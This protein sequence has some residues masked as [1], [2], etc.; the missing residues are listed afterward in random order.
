MK[1]GIE[2]R[3]PSLSIRGKLLIA[4]VGLSLGPLVLLAAY[5][6]VAA[7]EALTLA[8]TKHLR[9]QLLS[10]AG[11]I[12]SYLQRLA[13]DA[14]LIARWSEQA[15]LL[16]QKPA[17]G[18]RQFD[19]EEFFVQFAAVRPDIY[20]IRLLDLGGSELLRVNHSGDRLE[21]VP[22]GGLQNKSGRYYFRQ[23]VA[24]PSDKTYFSPIDLNVE[25][26]RVETPQRLV[27]RVA[28]QVSGREGR[29][30][31][32][33]VLNVF[34]SEIL[35]RLELLQPEASGN[36]LLIGRQG[37]F[38]HNVCANGRCSYALG[39]LDEYL[40]GFAPG[41]VASI[42]AGET[43]VMREGDIRMEPHFISYAPVQIGDSSGDMQLRLAIV[44]PCDVV[45]A[46]VDRM[47]RLFALFGGVVG[48]IAL[49]LAGLGARALTIPIQRILRFLRGVAQGDFEQDLNVHTRDEIEQLAHGVRETARALQ[50]AQTRLVGWNEELQA[51]VQRQVEEIERLLDTK[52]TMEQQVR[53]ADRLASLGLL[54]ASL[55]HEIGNPLASIKTVI[56]VH[57]KDPS[58]A[59][60]TRRALEIVLSQLDRLEQIL[61]RVRG[62]AR[63]M[64][65]RSGTAT[66]EEVYHRV[67]LLTERE[68]RKKEIELSLEGDGVGQSLVTEGQQLDQVLLNLVVNA[69]QAMDGPGKITVSAS[70][71]DGHVEATV[72]DTGPGIPDHLRARVF[73][74]FMTTK[75]GGTGL[76]LPIVRQIVDEMKGEVWIDATAEGGARIHIRL[77]L[78]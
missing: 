61:E 15:A 39:Q 36:V 30:S 24:L 1:L 73:E 74:P 57:L 6:T 33:I 9:A 31:G 53:Q 56:Q 64:R 65:G 62:F 25:H 28:H 50:E 34:A 54:S 66:I 71:G 58:V 5:G 35:D 8:N 3:L 40:A 27:F 38:V 20:Q 32:L 22:T 76:G 21:V 49:V 77:P 42:L 11:H 55:G 78:S 43:G 29:T 48:L 72:T 4:F 23:A 70:L 10:N 14:Q 16:D 51:E 44:Y 2:Q 19:L 17:G 46:P 68:A 18:P 13:G 45:M 69:M 59:E 41:I 37:R 75:D 26:G 52:Q 47:K 67:H 63:P 12:E 60:S 7:T